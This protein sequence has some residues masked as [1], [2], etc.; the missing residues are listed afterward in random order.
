MPRFFTIVPEAENH[1]IERF[2]KYHSTLGSGI[3][4]VLPFVDQTSYKHLSKEIAYPIEEQASI[5]KD[6]VRL[7]I[8]GVVYIRVLDPF[9]AS[10]HV[11]DPYDAITQL[12]QTT[13]RA[14]IGK[15]KLDRTFSERQMLNT[16]IVNELQRVADGWGI[17]INRYEISN[18]GVP[19][20]IQAAMELEAE[21]DRKKRKTI[22]DSEAERARQENEA[23]GQKRAQELLSEA[24]MIQEQ[25]LARGEAFAIERRASANAAAI[26]KIASAIEEGNGERAVAYNVAREYIEAFGSL[27]QETNTVIVPADVNNTAGMISQAMSIYNNL[28]SGEAPKGGAKNAENITPGEARDRLLELSQKKD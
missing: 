26:A 17:E 16:N 10:Y 21:A 18:I 3:H 8:D 1:I 27:A 14:E 4:F 11:Q 20:Q 6:N 9:R 22:L 13:M 2:G 15:I 7:D 12:A 28:S 24:E 19:P 23:L 5:T 25:N